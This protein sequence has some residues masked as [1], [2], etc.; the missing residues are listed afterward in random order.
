MRILLNF[1]VH[2]DMESPWG[3]SKKRYNSSVCLGKDILEATHIFFG[4]SK[5]T[6]VNHS[7]YSHPWVSSQWLG[8]FQSPGRWLI[9]A[10]PSWDFLHDLKKVIKSIGISLDSTSFWDPVYPVMDPRLHG[11][12]WNI[13]K[14]AINCLLHRDHE[15]CHYSNSQARIIS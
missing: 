10:P 3:T 11:I 1:F 8:S 6:G 4:G 13:L 2:I 12:A 14:L 9:M 7:V 5:L 15:T